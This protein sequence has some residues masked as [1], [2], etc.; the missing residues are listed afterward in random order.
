M[1]SILDRVRSSALVRTL[2]GWWREREQRKE[3]EFSAMLAEWERVAEG[4]ECTCGNEYLTP[5]LHAK[6]CGRWSAKRPTTRQSIIRVERSDSGM[7]SAP[8]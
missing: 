6:H 2:C 3:R 5:W 4:I 7:R 8:Q 1:R